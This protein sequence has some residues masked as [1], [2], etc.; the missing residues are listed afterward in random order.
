MKITQKGKLK[1][2][3]R[4]E[5]WSKLAF[6]PDGTWVDVGTGSGGE[7]D[8]NNPVTY[9]TRR[10]FFDTTGRE[11]DL[12]VKAILMAVEEKIPVITAYDILS[13]EEGG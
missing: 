8:G 13:W 9:L 11:R 2:L 1:E 10:S 12:M 6:W 4:N 7:Q 5:G 3:F